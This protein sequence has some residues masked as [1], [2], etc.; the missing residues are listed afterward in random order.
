M[1]LTPT[2]CA[3]SEDQSHCEEQIDINWRADTSRA[4]CLFVEAETRPLACWQNADS[5]HYRYRAVTADSLIFQ[6]RGEHSDELLAS[7][8]FKVIREYTDFRSRRRKP[9]NFF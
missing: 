4:L 1:T 6:L 8:F 7:E 3:L 2:V 5:G 9:W